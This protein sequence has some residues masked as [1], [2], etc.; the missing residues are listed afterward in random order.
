MLQRS[1]AVT[2]YETAHCA[3][4]QRRDTRSAGEGVVF[5]PNRRFRSEG[6]SQEPAEAASRPAIR[7]YARRPR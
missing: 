7:V 2:L 1:P 6:L 3:A 4:D 5:A